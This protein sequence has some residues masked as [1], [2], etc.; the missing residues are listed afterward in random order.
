VPKFILLLLLLVSSR[1]AVAATE[2]NEDFVGVYFDIEAKISEYT[3][4]SNEPFDVYVILTNPSRS[5][6]WGFE[7]GYKIFIEGDSGAFVRLASLLSPDAIDIG[8]STDPL[9]GEYLVGLASPM[10]SSSAVTLVTWQLLLK[11]KTEMSILLSGI[12]TSPSS[13]DG[14]AYEAGGVIVPMNV[15][16]YCEGFS[17]LINR[18]CLPKK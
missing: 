17:A 15:V 4:V 1:F 3:V 6:I 12:G 14:P 9:Q 11:N 2:P 13:D 8:T 16:D 7:F 18:S 10:P 5:L